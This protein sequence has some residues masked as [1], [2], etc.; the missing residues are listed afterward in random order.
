[1]AQHEIDRPTIL[2][3]AGEALADPRSVSVV[4]AG[5]RV[6]GDV[7]RR[8]R[9]ALARRGIAVQSASLGPPGLGGLAAIGFRGGNRA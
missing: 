7:D 3:V 4:V 1:M 8:I 5:G 6:R 9:A 2:I